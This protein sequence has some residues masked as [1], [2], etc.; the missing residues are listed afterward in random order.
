MKSVKRGFQIG[1]RGQNRNPDFKCGTSK[2]QRPVIRFDICMKCT[3]CWY[4]YPDEVFDPTSK[5]LYDV[6][7]V[8]CAG[9]ARCA[10]IGPVD[11]RI[12]MVDELKFDN[13]DSPY[14]FYKKDPEKYVKWAEEKK[15]QERLM[16]NAVTGKGSAVTKVTIQ[17]AFKKDV[18]K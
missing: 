16:P 6:N 10:E 14:L 13:Q 5:G 15:G 11:D 4:N 18:V 3:L 7:Y 17:K 8:Y 12:V 2:T 9:C 1:P